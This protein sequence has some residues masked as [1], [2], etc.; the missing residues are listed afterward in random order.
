M[1]ES[2]R[3]T[4]LQPSDS[5]QLHWRGKVLHRVLIVTLIIC[6]TSIL[7]Q[8]IMGTLNTKTLLPLTVLAASSGLSMY[9][10]RRER[11]FEAGVF[12]LFVAWLTFTY[13]AVWFHGDI[14]SPILGGYLLV[15]TAASLLLG[16]GYGLVFTALSFLSVVLISL[17]DSLGMLPTPLIGIDP[18]RS[19]SILIM[20]LLLIVLL[21][22]YT[23]RNLKESAEQAQK[24]E[25]ALLQKNRELNQ[26]RATLESQVTERTAEI[27]QQK[28]YFESLVQNSPL[29][30]V[31]LDHQHRVVAIN[32]AFQKLFGYSLEEVI[33]NELDSLITT[34]STRPEAFDYT[35]RVLEGEPIFGIGKRRTKDDRLVDV[36]IYGVPVVVDKQQLGVLGLYQDITKRNQT[37]TALR[38]SEAQLRNFFESAVIGMVIADL[39]GKFIRVNHALCDMLGYSKDELLEK[40]FEKITHPDDREADETN[41]QLLTNESIDHYQTE[42]RLIHKDGRFIWASS[43]LSLMRGLDRQ[44]DFIIG[45][46]INITERKQAETQLHHLATRDILTGLPNRFLFADRLNRALMRAQRSQDKVAVLFLDFDGFKQVNDTFGHHKGDG[47]LRQMAGRLSS[48]A[49]SSDTLARLGG[50]E[51]SFILEG[52][53]SAQDAETV[54]VKIIQ[55]LETPFMVEG[56]EFKITA[57]IGISIYPDDGLDLKTLLKTA[58]TAMYWAKSLGGNNYQYYSHL[59]N[60]VILG[61]N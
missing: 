9:L 18:F 37:E 23:T 50:D 26:I 34:E 21:I 54:P 27:V 46:V 7:F 41:I 16:I 6:A 12:Y 56:Q 20:N 61:D 29:A 42:K 57:S 47:V 1:L 48:C 44:P 32:Y 52:I 19:L 55:S 4:F 33:G 15:I 22:G 31:T 39:N 10:V 51:F 58:D 3:H 13:I 53:S 2:F 30:I 43:N 24:N 36:E 40:S 5:T 45:Q 8:F 59:D 17:A 25:K 38:E 35:L 14:N 28:Q 11:V 60:P 49:R